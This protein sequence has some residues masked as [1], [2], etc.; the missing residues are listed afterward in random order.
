PRLLRVVLLWNNY[1]MSC[2]WVDWIDS[3]C[4]SF[5]F[6][7]SSRRRH[8]R[9]YGDWSSD[10]CSS[11][12][13]RPTS[14]H[15]AQHRWPGHPAD[16][17]VPQDKLLPGILDFFAERVFGDDRRELLATDLDRDTDDAFVAWQEQ[18]TAVERTIADLDARR[19]RLLDA[20]E[21]T[22]DPDG[23]LAQDVNR[24]LIEIA[25]QQHAK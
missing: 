12:L 15:D 16:T 7:F 21:T 19:G 3:L 5:F 1:W 11:D 6:F 2:D 22:D 8:T 20:L 25:Q 17:Y 14:G 18:V 9:S 13:P 10:V 4:G 23:L 24:R